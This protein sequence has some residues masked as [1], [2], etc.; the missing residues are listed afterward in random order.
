ML[1]IPM[2][3]LQLTAANYLWNVRKIAAYN[4]IQLHVT[5]RRY[6]SSFYQTAGN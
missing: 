3:I 6:F 1:I 2:T 5:S 4:V